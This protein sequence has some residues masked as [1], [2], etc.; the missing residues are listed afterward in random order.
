[1]DKRGAILFMAV[2]TM[3]CIQQES[4]PQLTED[5]ATYIAKDFIE[6]SPTFLWDG[7]K[8]SIIII[9]VE[10]LTCAG[11]FS[12]TLTFKCTHG[13]YGDRTG[14]IMTQAITLHTA[15]ITMK[16]GK[17]TSAIID[18]FWD[19]LNQRKVERPA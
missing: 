6:K 19:E 2:V 1:M 8:G 11:C 12:V 15:I 18:D 9:L 5:D 14:K 10:P 7:M 16:K 4:V 17:V 3:G 13:G